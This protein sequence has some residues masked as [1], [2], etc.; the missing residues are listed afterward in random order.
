MTA[1]ESKDQQ[2]HQFFIQRLYTKNV[3]FESEEEIIKNSLQLNTD[4]IN[5]EL[6]EELDKESNDE[7]EYDYYSHYSRRNHN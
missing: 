7:N 2:Q 3:S 5:N 1:N 6:D 4:K